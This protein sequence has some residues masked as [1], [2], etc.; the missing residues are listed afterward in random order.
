[1]IDAATPTGGRFVNIRIRRRGELIMPLSVPT[2]NR[3]TSST[4]G[5]DI[6]ENG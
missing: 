3:G 2:T 6:I 1:M 4:P 5:E